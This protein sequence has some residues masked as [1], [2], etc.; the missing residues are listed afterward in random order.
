MFNNEQIAKLRASADKRGI[1][2][3]NCLH[4]EYDRRFPETAGGGWIY[5]GNNAPIGPCPICNP[6]GKHPRK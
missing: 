4:C 3:A 6:D 2:P 1:T 5:P